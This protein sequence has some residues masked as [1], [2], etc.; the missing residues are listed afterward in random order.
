MRQ[1][2]GAKGAATRQQ[3]L[4]TVVRL[5]NVQSSE[6]PSISLICRS[7]QISKAAFYQYFEDFN[8]VAVELLKPSVR[9]VEARAASLAEDW[10]QNEIYDRSY[11][12]V[13]TY[14]HHWDKHRVPL[15]LRAIL[16]DAC[17][18]QRRD[19]HHVQRLSQSHRR[20]NWVRSRLSG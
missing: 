13:A 1:R 11:V 4:D 6:V 12:F 20:S 7:A 19:D 16:A 8:A 14:F 10:P 15:R 9:D 18:Q 3:I 2:L 17:D 5:L